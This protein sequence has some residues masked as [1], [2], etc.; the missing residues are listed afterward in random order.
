MRLETF[1]T[2]F[3]LAGVLAALAATPASADRPSTSGAIAVDGQVLHDD[4]PVDAVSV[5][6]YE[7]ATFVLRTVVTDAD[8]HF[9]FA[10]LPAGLYKVVA[11]KPG[12]LPAIRLL[13]RRSADAAQRLDL[14]LV[15]QP[16]A[17]PSEGEADAYWAARSRVPADVLRQIESERVARSFDEPRMQLTMPASFRAD[18]WA[19]HGVEQLG[20][21]LGSADLTAAQLGLRAALGSLPLGVDGRFEQ[22][23]PRD[24]ENGPLGGEVTSVALHVG[25]E[26]DGRLTVSGANAE[27]GGAPD[28][29][30][31]A[32]DLERYQVQ[33]SGPVGA[34]G[35]TSV[36]A[37]FV[38]QSNFYSGGWLAPLDTPASSRSWDVEGSY[39]RELGPGETLRAGLRYRQT[40]SGDDLVGSALALF[41]ETVDLYGL[42]GSRA[43]SHV[44]VEYGMFSTL[45]EGG[46]SLMPRGGVVVE[47]PGDW[48]ARAMAAHRVQEIDPA[49]LRTFTSVLFRD[50]RTCQEVSEACYEVAFSRGSG[51][52]ELR[53]GAVHREIAET[54]RLY[55]SED[56]FDRFESLFLVRGDEVPEAQLRMVRRFGPRV[57]TKLESSYGNGGGGI[58][59]AT[60][61]RAYENRVQYLVTSFDTQLEQTST[62]IFVAFHR[63]EQRLSPVEASSATGDRAAVELDRLQLVLTQDLGML[64]DIASRWAVRLNL[65]LSRGANPYELTDDETH[66]KLT[67][68]FTVSF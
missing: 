64:A 58:F 8:G 54:L 30:D 10:S 12:F 28:H 20:S 42:A 11:Y 60:D 51:D 49:E 22:L 6:A 56:F 35:R 47:L 43:G 68:G 50:G 23:V 18:M 2:A 33:W 3:V 27:L 44:L 39:S 45:R 62:G 17:G 59:Y 25:G 1:P 14:R 34:R 40:S 57:L 55:F 7:V 4:A 36:S 26:K 38:E 5:Y 19:N 32:V 37:R 67:G 24:L 9:F 46:V 48:R 29:A 53:I 61:D 21:D 31:S 52:D 66:R 15:E 16:V 65:E 13:M 41:D 63:L